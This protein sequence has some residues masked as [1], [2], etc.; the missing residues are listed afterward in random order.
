MGAAWRQG[1]VCTAADT[2]AATHA[3]SHTHTSSMH[4]RP[5]HVPHHAANQ[6]GIED[7]PGKGERAQGDAADPAVVLKGRPK[8]PPGPPQQGRG[9]GAWLLLA[10]ALGARL[11]AVPERWRVKR[12]KSETQSPAMCNFEVGSQR[13]CLL[14]P[15]P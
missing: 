8:G 7:G 6:E 9:A 5:A 13:R 11:L 14:T 4:T 3:F 2:Q 12:C 10:L 1:T 15:T